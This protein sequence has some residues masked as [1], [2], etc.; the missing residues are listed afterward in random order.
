MKQSWEPDS[1][2]EDQTLIVINILK[3]I[4]EKVDSIQYQI[5]NLSR[6]MET[7]RKY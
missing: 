4:K 7:M 5:G 1:Q 3:D 6:E 2:A